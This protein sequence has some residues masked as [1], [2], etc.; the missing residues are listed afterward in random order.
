[1]T[2]D[3]R[4]EVLVLPF[5]HALV[6]EY[7]TTAGQLSSRSLP[8]GGRQPSGAGFEKVAAD[9]ACVNVPLTMSASRSG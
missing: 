3:A 1:M 9:M 4:R 2:D 8:T 6:A 5:G 7:L